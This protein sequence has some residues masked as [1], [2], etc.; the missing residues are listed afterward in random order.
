MVTGDFYLLEH[1]YV[2]VVILAPAAFFTSIH[3]QFINLGIRKIK[4]T[5][6]N[7]SNSKSYF[8]GAL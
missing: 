4:T 5:A 8:R 7:L 3:E 6:E 2:Y 1:I